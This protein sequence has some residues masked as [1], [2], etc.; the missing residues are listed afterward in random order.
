MYS[1]RTEPKAL[2]EDALAG[3]QAGNPNNA[4]LSTNIPRCLHL[5]KRSI[6]VKY[7]ERHSA[8]IVELPAICLRDRRLQVG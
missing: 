2:Q 5:H 8:L 1:I 4:A 7:I 6:F 3:I